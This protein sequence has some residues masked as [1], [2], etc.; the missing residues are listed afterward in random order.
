[1]KIEFI[2][3]GVSFEDTAQNVELLEV[4][5]EVSFEHR[6]GFYGASEHKKEY[7]NAVAVLFQN[8]KVGSL[9]ES[10]SEDSPQQQILK[11]LKSGESP[12][13]TVVSLMIPG[14]KDTFKKT[15]KL[16][17]EVS[18]KTPEVKPIIEKKKSFNEEEVVID[19]DNL[20]H[21]YK[22]NGVQLTSATGKLKD[23]YK[24]FNLNGISFASAKKWGVDEQHLRDL[25]KSLGDASAL[26]GTAIHNAL[27][28]YET[29]SYL[30]EHI[31]NA[32]SDDDN[33]ALPKHPLL[34]KIVKEFVT[35]NPVQGR[36]LTEVLLTDVSNGYCGHADRIVIIDEEKKICRVG[37]YKINVDAEVESTRDKALQ[38][39]NHLPGNK[40]TKYQIQMSIYANMLQKTG[41]T[42]EGLD[43]YVLEDAWKYY[44][45]PVL[46]VI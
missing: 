37:D 20:N 34:R 15:Y 27:E 6:P 14:P 28:H 43:I 23:F 41:W 1:M 40:I 11:M 19:Y 35:V 26:F 3:V 42:V 29:H 12:I 44:A 24:E 22:Y 30:G 17:V 33:Y 8:K 10:S 39:F 13:G 25:W 21:V 31:K 2:P 36:V 9:A 18:E 32:K 5:S 46:S 16:S 4:G 45:L 38:P 7:P